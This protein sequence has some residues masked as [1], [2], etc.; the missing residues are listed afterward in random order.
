MPLRDQ[1]QISVHEDITVFQ[2]WKT[3]NMDQKKLNSIKYTYSKYIKERNN[4]AF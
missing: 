1:A 2:H 4:T 3:I